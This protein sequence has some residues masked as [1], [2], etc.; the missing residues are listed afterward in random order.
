MAR[1]NRYGQEKNPLRMVLYIIAV[2]AMIGCIG[3]LV[4]SSRISSQEYQEEV[5]RAAA[6]EVEF[7]TEARETR[8]ETETETEKQQDNTK[9]ETE[10][11]AGTETETDGEQGNTEETD[12]ESETD[13]K[14]AAAGAADKDMSILV[15]N[16]TGRPGVAG[17][18]KSQLEEAGYTDVTPATYTE[19]V[20]EKT[21]IYA[22]TT[23]EAEIFKEQFPD[24]EV[25]V[26][27]VETGLEA[28]EGI[29][30]PEKCD[31]YIIVG[32]SDARSE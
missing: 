28:A 19:T 5:R 13:T 3:Y 16:G 21:V 31:V 7:E 12:N 2:L 23:E 11:G 1:R 26:G 4:Y 29:P 20:G 18:W 30:L 8:G 22:A 9:D 27:T 25:E 10:Q 17:Y 6:E 24:A 32:S 15:L 14:E